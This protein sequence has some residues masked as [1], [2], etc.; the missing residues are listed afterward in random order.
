MNGRLRL[1]KAEDSYIRSTIILHVHT[2][3]QLRTIHN[4]Y[5]ITIQYYIQL[6]LALGVQEMIFT[7]S[8][9]W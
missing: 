4:G 9:E 2:L 1:T 3:S 5:Q 8:F 7:L 6:M